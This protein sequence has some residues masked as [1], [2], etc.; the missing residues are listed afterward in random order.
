MQIKQTA[1][2]T[3]RQL[4]PFAQVKPNEIT[5][6]GKNKKKRTSSDCA[7]AHTLCAHDRTG[8]AEKSREKKK[9]SRAIK[10]HVKYQ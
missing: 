6:R 3:K 1:A 7:R 8:T 10:N 4:K 9:M 2:A 5:F